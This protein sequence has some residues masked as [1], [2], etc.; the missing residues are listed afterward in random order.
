MTP[1]FNIEEVPAKPVTRAMTSTAFW[2]NAS[3]R[4]KNLK[5]NQP[6]QYKFNTEIVLLF[7]AAPTKIWKTLKCNWMKWIPQMLQMVRKMPQM[8]LMKWVWRRK[9]H[10]PMKTKIATRKMKRRQNVKNVNISTTSTKMKWNARLLTP[11]ARIT[12]REQEIVPNV[13]LASN[14]RME[15]AFWSI[16]IRWF[17]RI[18][19]NIFIH[20]IN[21]I[22]TVA[23]TLSQPSSFQPT[24]HPH[25]LLS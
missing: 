14:W 23:P 7:L 13:F 6:P 5:N 24:K 20:N 3:R 1:V 25:I 21:I 16:D 22:R 9:S 8:P 10:C 15:N 17:T 18:I 19:H 2:I 4:M 11:C 12:T